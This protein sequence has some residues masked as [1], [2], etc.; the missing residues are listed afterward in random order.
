[1]NKFI[2][3]GIG[4]I[5]TIILSFSFLAFANHPTTSESSST[6]FT[7]T[8]ISVNKESNEIK[9]KLGDEKDTYSLSDS[10]WVNRNEKQATLDDLTRG[11]SVELIFNSKDQVAF[12]KATSDDHQEL[13]ANS[14]EV[15]E[16]LDQLAKLAPEQTQVESE[17]ASNVDIV[18]LTGT[19]LFRDD[20]ELEIKIEGDDLEV[21]IKQKKQKNRVMSEVKIEVD[22]NEVKLRGREA[23][24]LIYKVLP[25]ININ[26][27][28][29]LND[30]K[31][32]FA[33][34][35][36]MDP[37]DL[38]IKVKIEDKGKPFKLEYKADK[39]EDDEDDD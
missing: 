25:S 2:Y 12:I 32:M 1:M 16:D 19:E 22:D 36:E 37:K 13:A 8:F 14:E 18:S 17:E 9:V 35:F 6:V 29:D 38:S 26:S 28:S 23:E 11:D 4:A 34:E 27:E 10:V 15:K 7:S 24:K 5:F 30:I 3:M 31:N 20:G 39:D 21:K 33:K